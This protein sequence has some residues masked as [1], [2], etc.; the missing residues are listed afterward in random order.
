MFSFGK[1]KQSSQSTSLDVGYGVSGS[2]SLSDSL[3]RA[4]SGS[5]QQIAFEDI[6]RELYTGATGAAGKVSALVPGLT[7]QANQLFTGGV[8]FLDQLQRDPSLVDA[9]VDQLGE[10][11][12]RF[13]REDINPALVSRGVATGTLGG[14][15]QG[16][17]QGA[18]ARALTE[19]F[20]RGATGLRVADQQ[21][22]IAAA[23]AGLGALPGL[24]DVAE[25]AF[26]AELMPYSALS[27]IIGAP[28]TLTSSFS[29]SDAIAQ[30][31]SRAFSEDFQYGTS[32]STSK[33]SGFNIGVGW[34]SGGGKS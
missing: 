21:A 31:I 6:I 24:F 32:Q 4:R 20:T 23:T 26:G 10:D 1:Q 15:R 14:G 25:G 33:G 3:S 19:Q 5:G 11:L 9:Q 12:G 27:S 28:T 34:G 16:V 13:M 2:E 18:A 22:S 29:E 7:E 30:A 8:N 17:A